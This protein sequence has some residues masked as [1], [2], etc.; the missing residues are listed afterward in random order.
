MVSIVCDGGE[1]YLDT[2]FDE[3]WMA[4]RGLLDPDAEAAVGAVLTALGVPDSRQ[5][6]EAAVL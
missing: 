1:K 3:E 2:V 5:R 6:A 4:A